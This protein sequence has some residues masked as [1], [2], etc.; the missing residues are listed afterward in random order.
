MEMTSKAYEGSVMEDREAFRGLVVSVANGVAKKHRLGRHMEELIAF[1]F[2]GLSEARERFDGSRGTKFS[3]FAHYRVKGAMLDGARMM[4]WLRRRRG[5]SLD[6]E[7]AFV[8]HQSV[9]YEDEGEPGGGASLSEVARELDAMI[10][11]AA[12]IVLASEVSGEEDVDAV[13]DARPNPEVLATQRDVAMWLRREIA[14]LDEDARRVVEQSFFEG[15]TL[16]E[17]GEGMG[18]SKSWVSRVRSAA[19]RKLRFRLQRLELGPSS[20]AGG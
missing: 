9:R 4:G 12:V 5:R 19:L 3:T 20:L 8:E 10:G 6:A 17:I 18:C 11:E 15:Q 14:A 13:V 2:Q 1:G 7:R 16:E